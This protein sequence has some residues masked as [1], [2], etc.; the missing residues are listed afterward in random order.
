[1]S[2]TRR[3]FTLIELLV[4]IAII[5]VLISLLLPAVQSARESARR[6]QCTN[7]LKQIGL[8]LH[9]YISTNETVPPADII[10]SIGPPGANGLMNTAPTYSA[11]ARMLPFLEFNQ[12]YNAI[13]F[14]VGPRWGDGSNTSITANGLMNLST[15]DCDSFGA[16]NATASANQINSFLCPS[17][18]ELGSLQYFRFTP[19]GNAQLI[20]RYNYPINGGINPYTS[21]TTGESTGIAYVPTWNLGCINP[22]G[23]STFE[24]VGGTPSPPNGQNLNVEKPVSIAS[25]T[26]GTN[27]TAA[28]SEWVRGDGSNL[29]LGSK[30]GLG[31]VYQTA[32]SPT[33]LA[34]A[35]I[36]GLNVADI[37]YARD[38]EQSTVLVWTWKGDWWIG[39]Q[40]TYSH[41]TTPNR[42]SCLYTNFSTG[43]YFTRPW[44][45]VL[46]IIAA[47]SRHP[48][49]VNVAFCDGSVRFVKSSISP[50]A[51][52]GV[53]TINRGEVISSDAY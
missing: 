8:A 53:G 26:D 11:L 45:S 42:K 15:A 52:M 32:D 39:D 30:Q 19:G 25:I 14:N 5:A 22:A 29:S 34:G 17:D 4:V 49:G 3:G 2:R 16:I 24:M 36:V 27:N 6:S 9:N 13:N 48:G 43:I 46:N 12:I 51:W 33:S 10:Y 18:T 7:N 40:F 23:L 28:F 47:S 38:C 20:G 31:A 1:M 44:T 41:T 21:L 50:V 35:N 37:Q